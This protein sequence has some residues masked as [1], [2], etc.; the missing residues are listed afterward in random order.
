MVAVEVHTMTKQQEFKNK[1]ARVN[2]LSEIRERLVRE[3]T[4]ES[5]VAAYLLKQM[6]DAEGRE[7]TTLARCYGSIS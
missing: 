5:L 4:S 6:M 3:A 7:V 1:V 2:Q